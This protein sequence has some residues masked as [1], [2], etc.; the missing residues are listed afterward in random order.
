MRNISFS[1]TT[2][3]FL[4]RSKTVTRRLGWKFLKAGD[5]LMGCE[6][7]QGL[8]KGG[9]IVKLG[10]IRVVDVFQQPLNTML[11]PLYGEDEASREGFPGYSGADFVQMFCKHMKCTPETTVSRIEFEYLD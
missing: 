6:K 9:K 1:L 5:V 8:G 3:Q 4:D 11:N 2:P 7:C 10:K